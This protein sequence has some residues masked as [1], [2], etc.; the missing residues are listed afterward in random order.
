MWA[1]V[2]NGI[3]DL[4]DRLVHLLH[5]R[6]I[7]RREFF[8][9][10]IEP[11]FESLQFVHKDYTAALIEIRD[12]LYEPSM[13]L[14]SIRHDVIDRGRDLGHVRVHVRNLARMIA[15][16]SYRRHARRKQ[17]MNESVL[18]V[19]FSFARIVHDYFCAAIG[20][21][22]PGYDGATWLCG[23]A[24][25]IESAKDDDDGRERCIEAIESAQQQLPERWD[26]ISAVYADLRAL[27]HGIHRIR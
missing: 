2:V 14:E 4:T 19:T 15:R 21:P 17:S 3:A 27:S 16:A 22:P 5:N 18:D 26:E 20:D 10:E 24:G 6:Q 9:C 13:S 8:D 12:L 7:S 25:L 1:T 11:I 23:I